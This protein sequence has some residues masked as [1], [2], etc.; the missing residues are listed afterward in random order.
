MM[1][2]QGQ[3]DA[4][5]EEPQPYFNPTDF[6]REIIFTTDFNQVPTPAMILTGEPSIN[7]IDFVQSS[8]FFRLDNESENGFAFAT[9]ELAEFESLNVAPTAQNPN[10]GAPQQE[11]YSNEEEM[12]NLKQKEQNNQEMEESKQA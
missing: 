2:D 5:M 1:F 3:I 10:V 11:W 6:F 12:Q 8:D 4:S 9:E 7:Q